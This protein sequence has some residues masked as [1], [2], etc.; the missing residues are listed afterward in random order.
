MENPHKTD[1]SRAASNE[2]DETLGETDAG[3]LYPSLLSWNITRQCNLDCSHCYRDAR[4]NRDP[5]EL[6]TEE[7]LRLIEEIGRVGFRV[8]ILSGGEPLMR[9]DLYDLISA[10]QARGIRPVLGTNGTLITEEAARRLHTAGLARAGI[11]LDSIDSDYHNRLRGSPT[12]W[13]EAVA[14]MRACREIGLPFQVNTTVTQQNEDQLLQITDLAR[15][16][17][18]A[19]HHVFFL[20]P[21]GRGRQLVEDMVEAKRCE[22][23]LEA[24]LKRQQEGDLEIK[25]TCAPQFIRVAERLGVPIRFHTGCLAGRTYCV[26]IPN[27][28][29]QP[30]P[31]LPMRVGNVRERPFSEIWE[32]A[33]LFRSLREESLEGACGRCRWGK[34][35]FGCRARAYWATGGNYLAEDPWC[36]LR[37]GSRNKNR[38]EAVGDSG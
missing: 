4:E 3:R 31:Y 32:R 10:A 37:A 12:A 19:G 16:L 35:C 27:G 8:L 9:P 26:V 23:L 18:A 2:D 28:E 11:S 22:Q 36:E 33:E 24:L 6:T 13:Q 7:G 14:G 29:V 20:V 34:R 5:D 38:G 30:C 25:P 15:D 21:T 17:G 1:K